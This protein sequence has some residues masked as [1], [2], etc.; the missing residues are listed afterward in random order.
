M[1]PPPAPNGRDGRLVRLFGAV[2][3]IDYVAICRAA[4]AACL[5]EPNMGPPAV[6]DAAG[7]RLV[8]PC[9]HAILPTE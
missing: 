4:R 3:T 1:G 9:G 7:V 6:S 5:N 8:G 2:L